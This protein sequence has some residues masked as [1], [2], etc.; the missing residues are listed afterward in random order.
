MHFQAKNLTQ[1]Q[2]NS[3]LFRKLN[4]V[5]RQSE[6]LAVHGHN[7]SGKTTLL[8]ILTGLI[9]PQKG[10]V[11]FE[12]KEITTNKTFFNSHLSYLGHKN[13]LKM[14]LTAEENIRY[15][16]ALA[17]DKPL[18]ESLLS[19]MAKEIDLK[20][21][22]QKPCRQL[23][24]GQCRKVA[25]LA[26]LLKKKALWIMDEPFTALDKESIHFF[27]QQCQK[28]LEAE[29]MIVVSSHAELAAFSPQI[30]DLTKHAA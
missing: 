9:S 11:L 24:Q 3:L 27:K 17:H 1:Y 25:L 16:Y 20:S 8:K 21:S 12:E 15:H 19:R 7:G 2:G 29:G 6:M 14:W 26:L 5:L 23:S 22:L 30:I 13:S 18:S 28:H 4:F 10:Q